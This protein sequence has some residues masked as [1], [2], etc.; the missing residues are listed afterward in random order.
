MCENLRQF[1]NKEVLSD[2]EIGQ[3]NKLLLYL[4]CCLAGRAYPF[5]NLPENMLELVPIETYKFLVQIKK[6]NFQMN[7]FENKQQNCSEINVESF[8][9]L[10]LLLKFDTTQFL[11]VICT[12]A[13]TPI[14][15]NCDG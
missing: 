2:S 11:N 12:C 7:N 14:F 15:A 1:V 5:G 13:D 10:R 6:K 4:N 9:N 8:P 3:G